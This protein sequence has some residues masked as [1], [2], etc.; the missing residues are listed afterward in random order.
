[1]CSCVHT[2]STCL[3]KQCHLLNIF[4]EFCAQLLIFLKSKFRLHCLSHRDTFPDG[5]SVMLIF[6]HSLAAAPAI[7]GN[8]LSACTDTAICEKF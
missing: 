5:D 3:I 1:M 7:N 8:Q 2:V 4:N 6:M